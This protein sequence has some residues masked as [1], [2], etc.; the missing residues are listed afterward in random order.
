MI[1]ADVAAAASDLLWRSWTEGHKIP[2]LPADLRPCSRAEG[3]AI[4]AC[5]EARSSAPLFGWKIAATSAAGQRHIGVDGP[6]AGRLLAER[7]YGDG[8]TVPFGANAMRVAEA[9]FAFRIGRDLPPR[10]TPYAQ[11]EV[12]AA[13][14]DLHLAIEIPDSRYA[15][16]V[17]AGAPQLIADNACAHDFVLGPAAAGDWRALD[18]AAHRVVGRIEGMLEREG[19]GAN[20]LGDPRLALTWLAN[21][22]SGLGLTLGAGQVVT[23]GTCVVP[24]PI[25]PA[26]LVVADFGT[27]GKVSARIAA[28]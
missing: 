27:L 13:V 19:T 3:Y 11:D 15:D 20:V 10:D 21:E 5:L 26:D 23:T 28:R 18:L 8:D 17:T 2:A 16:F 22:L 9:E 4:Q 25:E 24:L 7:V 12:M 1:A 14:A 6:L